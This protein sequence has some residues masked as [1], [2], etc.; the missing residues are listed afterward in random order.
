M[1]YVWDDSGTWSVQPA[2]FNKTKSAN[3][4]RGCR[5]I[6]QW[7]AEKSQIQQNQR[8]RVFTM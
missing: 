3:A 4:V 7:W 8:A 2:D 1:H 6:T 5:L